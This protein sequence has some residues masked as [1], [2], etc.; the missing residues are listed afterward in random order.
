MS[1][2]RLLKGLIGCGVT[3]ALVWLLARQ[4]NPGDLTATMS[5]ADRTMLALSVVLLGAGYAMRIVRWWWM[6]HAL[7]PSVPLRACWRPFL[8]SI[9]LNNLLPFRVGDAVRVVGFRRSLNAP[10]SRLLATLVL[11]RLLDVIVLLTGFFIGLSAVGASRLPLWFPQAA[12]VAAVAVA[13]VAGVIIMLAA[14]SQRTAAWSRT[15][16]GSGWAKKIASHAGQL[17]ELFNLLRDVRFTVQLVA[18]SLGV[19]IC[20]GAVFA[21]VARALEIPDSTAGALFA[22]TTGTLATVLPSSPGYVGTFD[23]FAALGVTAF[24]APR[25]LAAAFAITVHL[26]LWLP[27]TLAGAL[28]FMWPQ[29]QRGSEPADSLPAATR[30]V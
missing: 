7:D 8:A 27:L 20:E 15:V 30:Q 5:R 28:C 4:F 2:A 3:L 11:E 25:E 6:L 12:T 10:A 13:V 1:K 9:A 22:L 14:R 21:T 29:T 24:G 18:L 19:W 17:L 16:E 23:Y 26:V